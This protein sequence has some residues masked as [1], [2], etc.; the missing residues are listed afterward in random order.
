MGVMSS[1]TMQSAKMAK[2]CLCAGGR[3]VDDV[4]MQLCRYIRTCET[5]V[6]K[7]VVVDD[8]VKHQSPTNTIA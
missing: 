5:V 8:E 7:V 6:A 1:S 3:L 2:K 4:A